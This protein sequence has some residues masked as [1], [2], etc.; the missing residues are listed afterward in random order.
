[1]LTRPRPLPNFV[2]TSNP[3][4]S[5]MTLTV[6][7]RRALQVDEISRAPLCFRAF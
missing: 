5:S 1:M 6:R 4:P 7:R 2:L 3:A